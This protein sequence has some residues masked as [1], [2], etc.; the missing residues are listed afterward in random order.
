MFELIDVNELSLV[1][2]ILGGYIIL[3]GL[4]SFFIKERLY[5]SEA[6]KYMFIKIRNN[7]FDV[8]RINHVHL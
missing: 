1:T 2:S 8:T 7:N 6:R 3:Y 4:V 5:L